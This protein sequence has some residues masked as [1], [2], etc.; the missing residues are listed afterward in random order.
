[1]ITI[2]K[3]GDIYKLLCPASSTTYLNPKKMTFDLS[4]DE[5]YYHTRLYIDVFDRVKNETYEACVEC[6]SSI[7]SV[8]NDFN[9]RY[10]FENKDSAIFTITIPEE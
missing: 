9:I 6:K 2:Q 5:T 8:V 3:I 1:M 10:D 4:E 7:P